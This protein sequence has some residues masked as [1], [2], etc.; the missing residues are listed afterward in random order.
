MRSGIKVSVRGRYEE[1]KGQRRGMKRGGR[2]QVEKGVK[3]EKQSCHQRRKKSEGSW[4]RGWQMMQE[5]EPIVL[6]T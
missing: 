1:E 2:R 5:D 4:R 6:L 3:V